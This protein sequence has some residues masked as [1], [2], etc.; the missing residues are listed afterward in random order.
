MPSFRLRALSPSEPSGSPPSS[1]SLSEIS[2]P[3]DPLELFRTWFAAAR[4]AMIEPEAM[5][6]ATADS[7]GRP[8]ARMVLL[9]GV[10]ARGFVFYTNYES[11]KGRELDANPWASLVLYW[12]ALQRQVRIE[13]RV[14]RVSPA[15]SDAYF[16]TR[17]PGSR[18]SAAASPQSAV[19]ASR[20]QLEQ[21]VRD[22]TA[23]QAELVLPRPVHWG[24][25][26]V[27]PDAIEFWQA[28]EHRLHDRIRYCSL[29]DGGW[30]IERL[31]P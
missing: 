13:G 20:A 4:E 31:A 30:A 8:S 12:A 1:V 16:A 23:A 21:R 17:A 29:T 28:G 26:R 11:R 2:V 6:L 7:Q 24:G 19:I 15:E 3:A 25:F 14:A 5:T 10:D 18:I 27:Q 9:R 22:L